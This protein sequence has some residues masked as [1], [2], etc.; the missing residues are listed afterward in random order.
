MKIGINCMDIGAE[1]VGGQ[2]SYT[3]G[4]LDA[5]L[6]LEPT[7]HTFQLYTTQEKAPLL[8]KYAHS[9]N[10][11]VIS[12]KNSLTRNRILWRILLY[13][14]AGVYEFARNVLLRSEADVM[15]LH[16]DLI[17]TPTT[18]LYYY[19]H[20]RPNVLSMHD[21]QHIHFPSFFTAKEL[22]IRATTY[23]LSAKN[24]TVLQ[25]SSEFSKTDFLSHFHFLSK[26]QVI[27]IPE[28]VDLNRFQSKKNTA[29]LEDKYK[30]PSDFL[31]YPAQLWHHKNHLR[32]L[33][34][35]KKLADK[36][37]PI[38]LVLTGGSYSASEKIIEYIE[39]H[40]PLHVS[41]LGK[42]P[43]EDLTALYQKARFLVMPSLHE[44]N[45]LPI[46]EA[47]ASGTPV[48][49]SDIPPNLELRKHLK[50]TIFNCLDPDS[51]SSCI[52]NTWN[53][54]SLRASH[55]EHNLKN[56]GRYTWSNSAKMYIRLFES[57][58]N[59]EEAQNLESEL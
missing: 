39:A 54:A 52:E 59:P 25:A 16:S 28:G 8:A 10:F 48:L 50:L 55:S 27:V 7:S 57:M 44:S 35:L 12:I 51:I 1:Y 29:Y 4:L 19:R 21:I 58:L 46:L 23:G 20:R 47:A 14:P 26:Q 41:Y 43:A 42:V 3:Y 6:S 40:L 31:L 17:Y 56:I 34:A 24:T 2:S 18:T 9:P 32:L 13:A 38:H 5:F 15:D 22:K 37:N 53:D 33:N 45:S 11:R 30:I 49:A 36:N